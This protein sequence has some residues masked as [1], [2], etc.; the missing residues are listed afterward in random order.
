[1]LTPN[2]QPL[3]TASHEPTRQ[4]SPTRN[5]GA[6]LL[7]RPQRRLPHRHSSESRES[8][9]SE[10]STERVCLSRESSSHWAA[11]GRIQYDA[12]NKDAQAAVKYTILEIT[13]EQY[14]VLVDLPTKLEIEDFTLVHGSAREPY[15]EEYVVTE[16]IAEENFALFD[17]RW[18]LVGHSHQPF[19][20]R[21]TLSGAVFEKFVVDRPIE[22][23]A[24]RL[25]INPGSV[26]QPR[27]RNPRASYLIYDSDGRT[28]T[29]HRVQYDISETQSKGR[30]AGLPN[31]L[32]ERIAYG[33]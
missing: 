18:C 28:I 4:R 2:R 6:G 8:S 10:R 13:F 33:M 12:F 9:S 14:S 29:N 11:T 17:T 21:Q 3:P 24:D 25:I 22:L 19:L 26:G 31:Y 30:A 27:D 7:G 32:I 5:L 15:W 16:E 1:M 20:C 23:G